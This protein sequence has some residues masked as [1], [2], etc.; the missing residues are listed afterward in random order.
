MLESL[1][2]NV[3]A[4]RNVNSLESYWMPFTNN[5]AFKAQPRVIAKGK[6]V[7]VWDQDGR[8]MLDGSS[9]L[10]CSP[11]GHCR[12][13]IAQAVYKQ[14]QEN[15][16]ASS[17]GTSH[18]ISFLFAERLTRLLP[19]GIDYAFFT[20]SGSESVDTAMKIALAY[21][22]AKGDG[23]RLRF[24][25]RER[26]YHG[27]NMGGTSL[28]GMVQNR[29]TFALTL[30][31][32]STIRHT[33]CKENS[34]ER[35]QPNEGAHLA[36][37]LERLCTTYGG[38]TIAAV[39]I[40]PV[41]GSTG[42]LV[43]PKGY[44][45]RIRQICDKYGILLILD[46]VITGFG[47]L[48]DPFA[49]HTFDVKPDIMTMAKA[50]TNGCVPMGAVG[51]HKNIYQAVVNA[52][53]ENKIEFPHGYTYSAH[54]AACAAGLA[55]LDIYEKE[56]L[57]ERA[58]SLTP[59]FLDAVWSLKEHPKVKDL[60]GYGLL[61]GVEIHNNGGQVGEKGTNLQKNLFHNGMHVK[62]TADVAILSPQFIIEKNQID[63]MI[64]IFRKTLDSD[65]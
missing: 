3:T 15:S 61:A 1:S 53:P 29:E 13:E 64:D 60:R 24:V 26:A 22:R 42:V 62:I 2:E 8:R 10:F 30:P 40:E 57:F 51:V 54:P 49:S 16:Y 34:F 17:F 12:S 39:F 27:V 55:T 37:D 58:K 21:H 7:E 35:G 31:N 56:N 41:A 46:E 25:S 45:Q 23:H 36:D 38:E 44:L 11:A 20:N 59:Y 9:G 19:E 33:M 28:S 5:R 6:G 18:P 50:L 47:R 63:E 32:I 65:A 43:P 52:A 48:G 4:I 14:L